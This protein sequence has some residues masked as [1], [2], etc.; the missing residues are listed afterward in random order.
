MTD[1]ITIRK[2]YKHR[3]YRCDKKD[4]K[5]R[6]MI[7]VAS[8][9]WNHMRALQK[10]YYRLTGKYI[11]LTAMSNHVLKLRKTQHFA[12]W[13]GLHSQACQEVCR[14]IDDAYQRFFSK[15]VK[16]PP[17]FRKARKYR[18]FTFPQSGYKV[19][20]HTITIAGTK[21][22]FVKHR[23]MN[24]Q[25]KTLTVKRDAMG[26]LWLVFSVV[27]A[28]SIRESST[29]KS[30]GFDFGLKTFLTDDEGRQHTSP[31]FFAHEL[32]RVQTL[33]RQLS[34][35]VEGS[36]CCQRTRRALAKAYDD[37]TNKRRDHHFKLAHNLCDEYDTLYFEDLNL[38]GMKAMWGRK[39]S[40][41]GFSS[42]MSILE[43][44]A[45]KRGKT[46]VRIDRFAPTTTVCSNCGQR[47]QLTLRD[48]TLHRACGLVIDRDHNAAITI[49]TV[50][51]STVCQ[52]GRKSQVRLRSRVDGSSPRL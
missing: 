13:Q 39:V 21:Y 17:R 6:H 22:K 10:R 41:L 19:A 43:W 20:G 16:H 49:K 5:L 4:N 33:H 23:A 40:D 47:H 27:E 45:L 25:I 7:F 51:A 12:L 35:K 50:G 1:S 36:R 24:G 44:V 38:A 9:V 32:K 31:L 18:S 52:S 15:R 30:G 29:G 14:R 11:R 26:R 37:V 48:R 34:R 28:L 8:T 46:I 2:T 42:F 3:L